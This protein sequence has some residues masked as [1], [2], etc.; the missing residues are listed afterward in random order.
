MQTRFLADKEITVSSKYIC[1]MPEDELSVFFEET[2][3]FECR[4]DAVFNPGISSKLQDAFYDT[5][6]VP[7]YHAL[8]ALSPYAALMRK[9][10]WV[11]E[12]DTSQ[13]F[14]NE[15]RTSRCG[16]GFLALGCADSD[17]GLQHWRSLLNV[18]LPDDTIT[19]FRFYSSNV[20]LKTIE[21]STQ[22]EIIWLMGPYEYLI[23]PLPHAPDVRWALARNPLSG[24]YTAGQIAMRYTPRQ[25]TWW[26]V[27]DKH[28]EAFQEE[29]D[30]VY[31]RN[32]VVF[33][34]E[35]HGE[36]MR[37]LHQ[38]GTNIPDFVDEMIV[39]MRQWGFDTHERQTR[40]LTALLPFLTS[41]EPQ[42][43]EA[44]ALRDAARDPDVA[45]VRL[46]KLAAAKRQS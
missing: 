32:L 24:E 17:A 41:G 25:G 43:E 27:S 42:G 38:D 29:M 39:E 1:L 20:L 3:S 23:I 35:E 6:E 44:T 8:F 13:Y 18:L 15:L 12:L 36:F 21:N 9:S 2:L 37:I 26:Q 40:C 30:K 19:H 14:W 22:S 4:V 16:W 28:M 46:E 5:Q 45:L 34:W 11:F 10:P 33:L 31:R 7:E